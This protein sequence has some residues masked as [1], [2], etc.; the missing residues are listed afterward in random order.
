MCGRY[1]IAED[2]AAEELRQIIE[3]VNRRNP[4]AKTGGEIRPG[5][6][7]P[8]LANSRSLQP[9]AYA[10]HWGYTLPDGKLAPFQRPQ[11]NCRG[12]GNLQR[13]HGPAPLPHS[14]HL[15][16]RMGA[17]RKGQDQVRHR[18]REQRYDLSRGH[19]PQGRQSRRLRHPDP[20]T[21]RQHRLHSQSDAGYSAIRGHR[22]LAQ[23]AVCCYRCA[24][25][26]ADGDGIPFGGIDIKSCS[27]FLT[28]FFV[29]I[30]AYYRQKCE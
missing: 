3:A 20:R 14:R 16:F 8:V 4:D 26:R 15:L 23:R 5:D 29:S 1:Y 24:E 22:R 21:G 27:V 30:C 17:S 12:E 7:V 19:L 10:M 2:D 6:T 9:G 25:S 28:A 18:A 11:R 13:R